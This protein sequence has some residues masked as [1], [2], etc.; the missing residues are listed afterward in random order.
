MKLYV[1]SGL[2]ADRSVFEHIQFPK[3]LEVI[4]VD[5]LIPTQNESF[6]HYVDRMAENINPNEPFYLLGYSMGGMIVQEINKKFPAQKVVI[7][8]SIKS[9]EGKSNLMKWAIKSKI[10]KIVPTSFFNDKTYHLYGM[11]R[12]VF[13]PKNPK[14]LK[15]FRVR[16]PYYIKWGIEKALEWEGNNSPD[17]VQIMG[18]KDIVFP[19]ENSSPNYIIKNATH[20]FP[21]TKA[22]EVSKILAKEFFEI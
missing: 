10:Y 4:F 7:M 8:A 21:A 17:I 11:M 5:W 3:H 9:S 12:Q 6:A 15:Y 14:I 16:E 1:F 20:L 19:I 22:K 2:G 18:D 13:D